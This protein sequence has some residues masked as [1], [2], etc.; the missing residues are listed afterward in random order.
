MKAKLL[1]LILALLPL[2]TLASAFCPFELP[3]S[4][5]SNNRRLVNLNIVQ[6]VELSKDELLLTYGGG[7][8]GDGHRARIALKNPEEGVEMIQRMKQTASECDAVKA[9]R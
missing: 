4:G 1:L 7:N 3:P 8:L 2:P 6:Y 5:E 9:Q